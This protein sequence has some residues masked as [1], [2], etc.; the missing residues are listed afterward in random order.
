MHYPDDVC[1]AALVI[2]NRSPNRVS[3]EVE[4]NGLLIHDADSA[5]HGLG[6]ARKTLTCDELVSQGIEIA[7][8]HGIGYEIDSGQLRGDGRAKSHVSDAPWRSLLVVGVIEVDRGPV[9]LGPLLRLSHGDYADYFDRQGAPLGVSQ[10]SAGRVSAEQFFGR[11]FIHD[12]GS[13]R[14]LCGLEHMP[15]LRREIEE[16][17]RV[18]RD[19]IV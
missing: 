14:S 5:S 7:W 15:G 12:R 17:E 11:L 2:D 4:V 19:P 10:G 18:S 8:R 3:T 6:I 13:A 9:L 1:A 16:L